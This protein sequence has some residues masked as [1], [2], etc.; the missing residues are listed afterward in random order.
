MG[1]FFQEWVPLCWLV[2]AGVFFY[3]GGWPV[4]LLALGGAAVVFMANTFVEGRYRKA[5]KYGDRRLIAKYRRGDTVEQF[6]W[7]AGILFVAFMTISVVEG[8]DVAGKLQA[9]IP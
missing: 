6:L 8:W 5:E 3:I 1:K 9:W 7:G 2:M 4:A